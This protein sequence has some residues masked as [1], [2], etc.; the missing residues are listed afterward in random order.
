[1]PPRAAPHAHTAIDTALFRRHRTI[2]ISDTHLGTRGCKAELLDVVCGAPNVTQGGIYP[3]AP[4]GSTLPGGVKLENAKRC[5]DAGA[6][7][8]VAASAIFRADDPPAAARESNTHK[9]HQMP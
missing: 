4:V 7:V 8:L 3:F 5:V 1:M 2:F 9:W 6:T